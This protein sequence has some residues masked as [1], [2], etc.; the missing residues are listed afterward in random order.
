MTVPVSASRFGE[1]V[2]SMTGNPWIQD[3]ASAFNLAQAVVLDGYVPRP[4]LVGITIVPDPTLQLSDLIHIQD[5]DVT[6]V[7]D[8]ARIWGWTLSI[9]PDSWS[10]TLD[11]RSIAPPGAWILGIPGRSELGTTSYLQGV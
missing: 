5:P 9:T 1:V 4:N 8:Y 6:M 3:F 11:A 7:D 10:M 2:W